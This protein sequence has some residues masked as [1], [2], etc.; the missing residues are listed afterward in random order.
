MVPQNELQFRWQASDEPTFPS[1]PTHFTIVARFSFKEIA[2][3]AY[4]DKHE[5]SSTFTLT[6]V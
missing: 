3:T 5:T 4:H 2:Y 6:K 1:K